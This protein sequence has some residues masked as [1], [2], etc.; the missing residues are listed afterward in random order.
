MAQTGH[1]DIVETGLT[2]Q[3]NLV[4][5]SVPIYQQWAPR[6]VIDFIGFLL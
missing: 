5:F 1:A 6:V 3:I 4:L 2:G